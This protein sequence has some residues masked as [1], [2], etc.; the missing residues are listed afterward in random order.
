[1][2]QCFTT[3]T[4]A[5]YYSRHPPVYLTNLHERSQIDRFI[6]DPKRAIDAYLLKKKKSRERLGGR[7]HRPF[8][9]GAN[10][11]RLSVGVQLF[12]LQQR[13][14]SSPPLFV[15]RA[16]FPARFVICLGSR[17][18]PL[19]SHQTCALKMPLVS[20]PPPLTSHRDDVRVL[21]LSVFVSERHCRGVRRGEGV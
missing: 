14:P 3:L 2:P 11:R 12:V 1:M 4:A 18:P 10:C 20:P 9:Q 5:I 16:G 19:C 6:G 17:V 15:L 13:R 7:R 8:L 21:F